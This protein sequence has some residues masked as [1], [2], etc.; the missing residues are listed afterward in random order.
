MNHDRH[1]PADP[2]GSGGRSHWLMMACCVPMIVIALA[3]VASGTVSIGFL[4]FAVLCTSMM[5]FMMRGMSHGSNNKQ[6]PPAVTHDPNDKRMHTRPVAASTGRRKST[7]GEPCSPGP[8]CAGA[9]GLSPATG[10][11]HVHP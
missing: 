2:N 9:T 5:F 1:A 4:L 3:L 6:D 7:P 8:A 10:R 11:A